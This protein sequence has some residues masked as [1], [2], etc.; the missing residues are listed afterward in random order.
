MRSRFR[1][2]VLAAA[3][4]LC[5]PARADDLGPPP[6]QADAA[7]TAVRYELDAIRERLKDQ[8]LLCLAAGNENFMRGW[9]EPSADL[10]AKLAD[11]KPAIK[12]FSQC[13]MPRR[14]VPVDSAGNGGTLITVWSTKCA[15][16][17]HCAVEISVGPKGYGDRVSVAKS[18]D[19]WAVTTAAQEYQDRP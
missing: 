3:Q 16:D 17:S 18:A 6:Y 5:P 11:I 8:S 9:Q 2:A 4:L 1:Y 19:G 15:D 13:P 7:Q 12:A 14:G 10:L